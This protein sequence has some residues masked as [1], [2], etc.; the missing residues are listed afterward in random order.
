MALRNAMGFLLLGAVL[1]LAL[2][3][4]VLKLTGE[5]GS[6]PSA[7]T[8]QGQS[9]PTSG[10]SAPSPILVGH[11]DAERTSPPAS[12]PSS[13]PAPDR[14]TVLVLSPQGEPLEGALVSI[15]PIGGAPSQEPTAE[16]STGDGGLSQIPSTDL[17]DG[18]HLLIATYPGLEP[19]SKVVDRV[20][21]TRSTELRLGLGL[22]LEGTVSFLGQPVPNWS[23]EVKINAAEADGET[24]Q[25]THGASSLQWLQGGILDWE[26]L[27]CSTDG[28]GG[29]AVRGLSPRTC[30]LRLLRAPLEGVTLLSDPDLLYAG[31]YTPPNRTIDWVIPGALL[32]LEAYEGRTPLSGATITVTAGYISTVTQCG[33][34]GEASIL[35]PSGRAVGL[36]LSH[37]GQ[38]GDVQ[39][40][41]PL[42]P[43]EVRKVDLEL[44]GSP[45][46][47]SLV[48][49]V[50][51]EQGAPMARASIHCRP[52][53]PTS[54]Q[55]EL[56]REAADGVYRVEGLKPG[57]M[58]V[59]VTPGGFS[60]DVSVMGLP[61]HGA[62]MISPEIDALLEV[63]TATGGRIS[64]SV[65]EDAPTPR[66]WTVRLFG[67]D[68]EAANPQLAV[69]DEVMTRYV[70][71]SPTPPTTAF[72]LAHCLAPGHY[73]V[74]LSAKDV[75]AK[76]RDVVVQAGETAE[77]EIR[78]P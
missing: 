60:H 46:T 53:G 44:P 51:D 52:I 73:R 22:S 24:L 69:D 68:G 16:A 35:V 26:K 34:D 29:F 11:P 62:V 65:L 54:V 4:T 32:Q 72:R 2:G 15:R 71:P 30:L 3:I 12:V 66:Q 27:S 36:R 45:P 64:V 50:A 61:W 21:D 49:R 25:L 33:E 55:P 20:E 13:E 42:A 74:E 78:L 57:P 6:P 48:L 14:V 37:G 1:V 38:N 31:P 28:E 76:S 47:G 10:K 63:R 5:R 77:L 75:E 43:G 17:T 23:F 9:S 56:L 19:A 40:L 70:G 58:Q 8:P 7:D 59:T 41:D 39:A 67:P 18:A